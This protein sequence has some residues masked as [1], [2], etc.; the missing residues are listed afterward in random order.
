MESSLM[1]NTSKNALENDAKPKDNTKTRMGKEGR[2][3]N[4]A[5][6]RV[7]ANFYLAESFALVS[8]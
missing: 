3:G 2:G 8:E 1:T 6:A 5:G 4:N 7:F